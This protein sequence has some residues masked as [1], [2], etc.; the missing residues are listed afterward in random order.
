M[1]NNKW[2][3]GLC[4]LLML[5][6]CSN[7]INTSNYQQIEQGMERSQVIELLGEPDDLSSMSLGEISGATAQWRGDGNMITVVFANQTVM[8]K[9]FGAVP[10]TRN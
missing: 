9:S 1:N 10:N 3:V 8:F 2:L 4:M 7:R 5:A 6:A